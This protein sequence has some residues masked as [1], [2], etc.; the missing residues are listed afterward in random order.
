MEE[1]KLK[2]LSDLKSNGIVIKYQNNEDLNFSPEENLL[3]YKI[4]ILGDHL[5]GKSSLCMRFTMNEFNLEIKSSDKIECYVKTVRLFDQ[6]IKVYL[7]DV[8]EKKNP[9]NFIYNDVKGA[10]LMYD[11]TKNKSFENIEIWKDELIKNS[12]EN[13][14]FILIG[15]KKDLKFL[16]NVDNDEATEKSN[17][18]GCEFFETSCIE[19][20]SV[21]D[22]VKILIARIFY[23]DLNETQKEHYRVLF[24]KHIPDENNLEGKKYIKKMNNNGEVKKEEDKKKGEV[25]DNN[26][27]EDVKK[28]DLIKEENKKKD[29]KKEEEKKEEEKKEEEK[30]EEEKKEEEKKEEE[31][32]VDEKKEEE[33]KVDEKK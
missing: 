5:V 13:V 27:K 31:K 6:T 32:K 3:E 28:D 22:A 23:N 14:P 10:I 17:N 15:N 8:Y 16:R 12:G 29:E 19:S 25:I 9:N 30:K 4:L 1:K 11:I 24:N 20:D 26:I 33:K 18:F 2:I 21:I 7:I